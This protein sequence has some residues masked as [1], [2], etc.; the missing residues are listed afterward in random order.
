MAGRLK[1]KSAWSAIL[2]LLCFSARVPVAVAG[3][4]QVAA[5]ASLKEAIGDLSRLYLTRHRGLRVVTNFGGSGTIAKQIENGA[6]ADIFIS[7]SSEWTE[8]LQKRKLLEPG[9]LRPLAYNTLVFAGSGSTKAASMH[10]LPK[11]ERIAM[12]SPKSVPAGEYAAEAIRKAGL[13]KQMEKRVVFS[14][15]VRESLMYAERGDVDGAFVYRTDALQGRKTRI[16]FEVPA[17]LHS[18]IVYP[19]GLTATGAG[20]KEA[21]EFFRFLESDEAKGVLSRYGF[22]VR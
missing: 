14:R 6:P 10:D 4:I 1:R 2:L 13:E 9:S 12:G 21:A 22:A 17:G 8:Y 15:D 5:A 7:A 20:K 19:M 16:L 11:L 3:E 18:R